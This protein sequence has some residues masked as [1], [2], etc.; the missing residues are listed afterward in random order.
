MIYNT[1]KK[2]IESIES[3]GCEMFWEYAG[4]FFTLFY[5]EFKNMSFMDIPD[6]AFM[7]MEINNWQ[8][9]SYRCGVWQYYESGA[10]QKG[11]FER[12]LSFL[13]SEN[14]EDMA[15]VYAYGI[16]DYAN[17]KYQENFDYPE[18]WFDEANEI[19]EWISAHES[20][21]YRWMYNLILEHKSEILKLCEGRK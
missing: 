6:C 10:F 19:D 2:L 3:A 9:M 8:G 5:D 11:K 20:Y 18:E 15:S 14:E 12:V 4:Q 1:L 17:A 13:N 7:F 21:L 16:H